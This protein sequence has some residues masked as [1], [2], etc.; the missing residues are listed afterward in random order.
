LTHGDDNKFEKIRINLRDLDFLFFDV[1]VRCQKARIYNAFF[2]ARPDFFS[3]TR[4]FPR[5]IR[6]VFEKWLYTTQPVNPIFSARPDYDFASPT[7]SDVAKVR[8]QTNMA[9]SAAPSS[10]AAP[11]KTS[12]GRQTMLPARLRDASAESD[13]LQYVS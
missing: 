6:L 9:S 8:A 11:A 12:S 2:V 13:M 10:S 4:F 1:P 5:R 7:Q 3:P